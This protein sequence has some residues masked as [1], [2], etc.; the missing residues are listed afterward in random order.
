MKHQ[1]DTV[2]LFLN[3]LLTL[4]VLNLQEGLNFKGFSNFKGFLNI[5]ESSIDLVDFFSK[6]SQISVVLNIGELCTLSGFLN[7]Y[8]FSQSTE[9]F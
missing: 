7:F 4:K 1:N 6:R 2:S 9:R 3:H 5:Q 8:W